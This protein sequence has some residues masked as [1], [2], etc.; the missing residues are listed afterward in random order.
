MTSLSSNIASRLSSVAWRRMSSLLLA[1]GL[2]AGQIGLPAFAQLMATNATGSANASNDMTM[3][4]DTNMPTVE[5]ISPSSGKLTLTVKNLGDDNG[6]TLKTVRSFRNYS[7]TRPKNWDVQPASHIDVAFQHSPNLLPE[8]SSLNVSVN[9][10]ILK[11]IRLDGS[12]VT[13][14]TVKVPLPADILKDYNT[15][16]FDVNQHYTYKC[17]DPLSPELWTTLLPETKLVMAYSLK[18]SEP[19]L[20]QYPFPLI[21]TLAY[22]ATE[23]A[24][25]LPSQPSAGTLDASATVATALGQ[26][27]GWRRLDA[28]ASTQGLGENA[29]GVIVGTP[30]ENPLISQLNLPLALNGNRFSLPNGEAVA[31]DSGV[32]T[33]VTHP[34]FADK[35]L[36][37]VTGETPEAVEKAGQLIAQKP[38][39]GLL[40]GNYVVVKTLPEQ[41]TSHFRE[42]PGFI[43]ATG[44]TSLQQL[45]F[46]TLTSRGFTAQP[47]I[48]KVKRMPDV[49]VQGKDT[50]KLHTRYSYASQLNP[51]QS[52]LEV[53]L[54]G[55]SLK[56]VQLA[57]RD[58]ENNAELVVDIP[59]GDLFTYNDLEFQF[60][61]YPDKV[62][63]CR[64]VTDVHV[65]GTIHNKTYFEVPGQLKAALPDIGLINDAAFPLALHA[66]FRDVTF[67]MPELP[68]P[69]ETSLLLAAANR[70]GRVSES[71]GGIYLDV[72][73]ADKLTD[74]QKKNHLV[75][76]GTPERQPLF[77]ELKTKAERLIANGSLAPEE[78]EQ[79]SPDVGNLRYTGNQG[80]LEELINPWNNEHVAVLF[81]G[82]NDASL[83]LV[84]QLL[85]SDKAFATIDQGN[86]AV[87]NADLTTQSAILVREG[88]ARFMEP[89]EAK[90]VKS[91]DIPMWAWITIGIF[92][93]FGLITF[94]RFLF[95]R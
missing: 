47:I 9:N 86:I 55:K 54:N 67:V 51:E 41:S 92:A 91:T 72:T 82:G 94:L 49:L 38:H 31:A 40:N 7:F 70:F 83:K 10:R 68:T 58:G 8:R 93:V 13:A 87:V 57:N 63:L 59:A 75:V 23:I 42:W 44:E 21:D 76:I 22:G 19:S 15:L 3:D 61:L 37:V 28:I 84:E 48:Y 16:T 33:Y 34:T 52:K 53:L 2:M 5:A 73:T 78:D 50:I 17:E 90:L 46:E 6:Y 18:K 60:Y 29:N 95:I 66:D 32:V 65:W 26:A 11:T 80:V 24:Y 4:G 1:L 85:T 36:L 12:N 14:S 27:A 39:N 20:A 88:Q 81:T 64:F 79:A 71:H 25:H 43:N 45:G 69:Q 77:D 74:S 56:S 30:S 62:D 35:T 89:G